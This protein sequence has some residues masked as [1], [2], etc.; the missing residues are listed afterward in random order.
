M[1]NPPKLS[2]NQMFN[3]EPKTLA[4]LQVELFKWQEYNF[5][6]QEDRRMILGI[7]EEA[8]E[9]C[10]A[11]LKLEQ[12]IRGGKDSL[13]AEARDAVGDIC[14]YALNLLSNRKEAAPAFKARKDVEETKDMVRIGDAVLD[15]V[16]CAGRIE[17]ARKTQVTNPLPP[18]PTAP[19]EIAP[20]VRHTQELLMHVNAFCALAGWNLEEILRETWRTV[21][22]RD[23]KKYPN[24]GVSEWK[25]D[26]AMK[27]AEKE[28]NRL[29]QLDP[30]A[31]G[32]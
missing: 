8:G 26:K 11:H 19:P 4:D 10:H 12:G 27:E 15:L 16:C 25:M 32:L 3:L 1:T 31:R 5:G 28:A 23:F 20:I 14:I 17:T 22:Q 29:N 18:H 9:L 7:C 6:E 13:T 21:G 24:N 30:K 2:P